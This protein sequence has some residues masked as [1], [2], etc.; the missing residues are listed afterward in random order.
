MTPP[1][2]YHKPVYLDHV[3]R[4]YDACLEGVAVGDMS[5]YAKFHI[6]VW[7]ES[8]LLSSPRGHDANK[9][10]NLF[11]VPTEAGRRLFAETLFK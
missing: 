2:S 3:K 7:L 6:W 10:T 9:A 4:E 1:V 11:I 8:L 5:S